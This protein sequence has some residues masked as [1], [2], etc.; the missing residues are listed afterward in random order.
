[1]I[2]RRAEYTSILCLVLIVM[3]VLPLPRQRRLLVAIWRAAG[4]LLA[5]DVD[6]AFGR[7]HADANTNKNKSNK[8]NNMGCEETTEHMLCPTGGF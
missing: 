2:K 6:V 4:G 5:A 8:C 7:H 1:M 3:V